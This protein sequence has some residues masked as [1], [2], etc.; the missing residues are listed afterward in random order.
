MTL[1]LLTCLWSGDGLWLSGQWESFGSYVDEVPDPYGHTAVSTR[2]RLRLEGDLSE[3]WQWHAGVELYSQY[4]DE[5]ASVPSPRFLRLDDF[6][7]DIERKHEYLIQQQLDRLQVVYNGD[8]HRLRL[9]R[10]A[11]GF[12]N[13]RLLNPAD[14]FM[15]ISTYALSTTY[16]PGADAARWTYT[17]NPTIETEFLAVAAEEGSGIQLGTVHAV[18]TGF[19]YTLGLGRND[20][21]TFLLWDMAGDLFGATLYQEGMWRE[22]PD[23]RNT[24]RTAAGMSRRFGTKLDLTLETSFNRNGLREAGQFAIDP[25]P[26]SDFARGESIL[27]ARLHSAFL[28]SYEFHPLVLGSLSFFQDWDRDSHFAFANFDWD[29][30]Q[31]AVLRLGLYRSHGP[32]ESE[33]GRFSEG[34]FLEVKYSF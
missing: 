3:R 21:R 33:F 34:L 19:D 18:P 20:D 10:Q 9:G 1:L 29:V 22:E 25:K 23:R 24:L 32:T 13:G 28:V 8:R 14:I 4:Q 27:R 5:L 7:R 16:K 2:L 11:I 31:V 30:S 17:V 6:N 26:E 12:G 15:P